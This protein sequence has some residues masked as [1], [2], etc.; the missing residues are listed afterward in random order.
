[1]LGTMREMTSASPHQYGDTFIQSKGP[2]LHSGWWQLS[3]TWPGFGL[4]KGASASG[5]MQAHA[6]VQSVGSAALGWTLAIQPCAV[7]QTQQ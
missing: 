2:Y 1:M 5:W 3:V 7:A 6:R 4:E